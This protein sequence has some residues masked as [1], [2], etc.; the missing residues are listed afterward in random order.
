MRR[1]L[2]PLLAGFLITCLGG[3]RLDPRTENLEPPPHWSVHFDYASKPD[4][5]ATPPRAQMTY[6][7][8]DGSLCGFARELPATEEASCR[9]EKFDND[10]S[11]WYSSDR[12]HCPAPPRAENGESCNTVVLGRLT[13][14]RKYAGCPG[15]IVLNSAEWSIEYNDRFI[16]CVAQQRFNVCRGRETLIVWSDRTPPSTA[17]AADGITNPNNP[18]YP[19]GPSGSIT[20][21]EL[22][23]VYRTGW[24]MRFDRGF[25]WASPISNN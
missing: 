21:T 1:F 23:Q 19:Y 9:N 18:D 17:A 13:S 22:C 11:K 10:T 2:L 7:E 20:S 5:Y 4:G 15:Y 8:F 3:L 16:G 6:L 12:S 14:T 24:D 25:G